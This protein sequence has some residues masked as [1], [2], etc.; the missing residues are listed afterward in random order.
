MAPA[1]VSREVLNDLLTRTDAPSV[2]LR[3]AGI[4]DAS[5]LAAIGSRL[6]VESHDGLVH[7]SDIAA[8]L[9]E[10]FG[11]SHQLSELMATDSAM[12]IAET[13]EGESAG[14]AL[15]RRAA[16]PIPE[17]SR[18]CFEVAH[19]YADRK[20]QGHRVTTTLLATCVSEARAWGGDV[21]WL[22]VWDRLP[23]SISFYQRLGLRVV[24]D[25]EI[26]LGCDRQ[27]E[28]LLALTLR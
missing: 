19:L 11:E 26:V 20:S 21:L 18:D 15:L 10:T 25:R 13:L 27:R 28:L 2:R 12:W 23:R 17:A 4:D 7:P 3:R 9:S 1:R 6:F 16:L 22:G 24:G 8:Y 5:R 14:L